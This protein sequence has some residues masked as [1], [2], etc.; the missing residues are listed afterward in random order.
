MQ[1]HTNIPT[2]ELLH[3]TTFINILQPLYE[4]AVQ[5]IVLRKILVPAET[6]MFPFYRI[7]KWQIFGNILHEKCK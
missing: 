4:P 7:C 6:Y 5:P 2:I 3:F 1:V